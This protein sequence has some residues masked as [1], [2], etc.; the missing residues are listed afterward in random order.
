MLP[1]LRIRLRQEVGLVEPLGRLRRQSREDGVVCFYIGSVAG[2]AGSVPRL[3]D[4]ALINRPTP[5]PRWPR[6]FSNP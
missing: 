4:G 1:I 6:I 3:I 2:E 5:S